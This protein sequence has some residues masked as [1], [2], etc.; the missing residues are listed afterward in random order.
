MGYKMPKIP[1]PSKKML[2]RA[3]KH[4]KTKKNAKGVTK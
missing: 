3:N 1:K 2:S 4:Q